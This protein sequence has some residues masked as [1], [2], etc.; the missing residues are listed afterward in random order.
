VRRWISA[1]AWIGRQR[2]WVSL[3]GAKLQKASLR[4][5][6][7]V[8]SRLMEADLRDADLTHI[9]LQDAAIGPAR[10]S[11]SRRRARAECD[12]LRELA[13]SLVTV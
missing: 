3:K 8:N 9:S 5:A 13:R 1:G 4:N 10:E 6:S 12:G 11:Q 2:Q 7:I